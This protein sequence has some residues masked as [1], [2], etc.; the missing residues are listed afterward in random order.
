MATAARRLITVDEF[1][2]LEF[3]GAEGFRVELDNGVISMMAGGSL[4]HARIQRNL[5][6]L[7]YAA[8]KDSGCSPYGSDVGVRTHDLSL[9]YP[10]VTIMCGHSD[11]RSDAL[12]EIDDPR[13]VIEILSPST[14]RLDLDTKLHEYC[15]TV[16]LDA[17]IYIDPDAEAI[18]LLLR[19][20]DRSWCD[21]QVEPGTDV[22]LPTLD[23]TLRWADVF[24]R[25]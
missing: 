14:R 23:V 22:V 16:S 19:N 3:S 11:E 25:G 15:A 20:A 12:F 4:R 6:G 10:D 9:R 8:L 5:I 21:R 24:S 13:V 2:T 18:R 17:I 7:L 1:L